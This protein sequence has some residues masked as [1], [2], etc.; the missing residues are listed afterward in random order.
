MLLS[1]KR[2]EKTQATAGEPGSEIKNFYFFLHSLTQLPDPGREHKMKTLLLVVVLTVCE[3]APEDLTGKTFSFSKETKTDYVK[4]IPT[5]EML[6]AITVCL[7][8][9]TDL[10]RGHGLFSMSTTSSSNAFLIFKEDTE[11]R[12]QLIVKDSSASLFEQEYKL[13]TWHS[14]CATWDGKT[15]VVQLWLDGRPSARKYCTDGTQSSNSLIMIGQ[16]QDSHGGRF[17]I[18]QSFV[19]MMTDV[20]MWNFV[21]SPCEIQRYVEDVNYSP[22]NVINWKALNYEIVGK[23]LVTDKNGVCPCL[24]K[25]KMTNILNQSCQG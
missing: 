21:L 17:D 5:N 25:R 20:H 8:S 7:R 12:F 11:N 24:A 13:N 9:F 3:A 1:C 14:V 23:I 22:G 10:K 6:T 4:L 18:K 15:G 2:K 19:G 16:E